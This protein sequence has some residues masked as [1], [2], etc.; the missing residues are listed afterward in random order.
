MELQIF[1]V[2]Q[3]AM[4][5]LRILAAGTGSKMLL[6]DEPDAERDAGIPGSQGEIANYTSTVYASAQHEHIERRLPEA[7]DL[8]GARV[9]HSLTSL[10]DA[11]QKTYRA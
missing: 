5:E 4:D 1:Q 11:A 2:S 6:F 10:E 9:R 7:L 3:A 8:L